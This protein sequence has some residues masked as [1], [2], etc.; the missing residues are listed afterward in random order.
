MIP[1][2]KE[3]NIDRGVM[4]SSSFAYEVPFDSNE[5]VDGIDG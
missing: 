2:D 3:S 4:S 5:D 1:L